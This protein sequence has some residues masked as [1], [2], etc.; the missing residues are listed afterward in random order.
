MF[1]NAYTK[2]SFTVKTHVFSFHLKLIRANVPEQ[3]IDLFSNYL[4]KTL[5]PVIST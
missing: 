2:L 3:F 1:A 4:P 5:I